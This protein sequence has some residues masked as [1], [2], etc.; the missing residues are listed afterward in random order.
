MQELP[1]YAALVTSSWKAPWYDVASDA[2]SFSPRRLGL[3]LAFVSPSEWT[4]DAGSSQKGS[5][6]AVTTE[7][8]SP[9]ISPFSLT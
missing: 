5:E 6:H 7:T 3:N 2:G 1:L 8:G 9:Q 4:F